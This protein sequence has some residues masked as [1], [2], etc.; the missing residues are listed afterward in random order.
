[1]NNTSEHYSTACSA[2]DAQSAASLNATANPL[3]KAVR[4]VRWH[5]K[6]LMGDNAYKKYVKHQRL[7]HPDKPVMGEREFWDHYWKDKEANPGS[8]CC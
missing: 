2:N 8:R 6:E 5:V 1:M 3:V 4:S 7:H